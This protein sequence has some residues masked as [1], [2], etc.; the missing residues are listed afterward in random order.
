MNHQEAQNQKMVQIIARCWSDPAFKARLLADPVATLQSLG[1]EVPAGGQLRVLADTE[2]VL[3]L[4]IP[5]PPAGLSDAQLEA[6]AGGQS[7]NGQIVD[8][9]ARA[10]VGRLGDLFLRAPDQ[11]SWTSFPWRR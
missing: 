3:H 9:V 1:I 8:A 4:V 2:Q 11:L 5:C 7:V 10:N 6:I